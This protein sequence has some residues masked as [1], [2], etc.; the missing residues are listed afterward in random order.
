MVDEEIPGRPKFRREEVVVA[1]EAFDVYFRDVLEC[2][3]ALYGDP[4]FATVLVF[5]PERHYTDVDRTKRLYH[6]MHTGTWCWD[7]QVWM[8]LIFAFGTTCS[9]V[10]LLENCGEEQAG[11]HNRTYHH[12]ERQNP[13]HPLPQ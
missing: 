5:S 7:T 1:G 8:H 3:K 9:C 11:G 6:D 2:I 4:E 12:L 10:S 13:D